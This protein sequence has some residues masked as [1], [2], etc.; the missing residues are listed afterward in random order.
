MARPMTA[1]QT[2]AAL[3]KWG[4]RFR[5]YPGWRSRGRPGGFG[6][7]RGVMVHHTGSNSQSNDY[8]N[9]LF[10]RGRPEDGIPGPL[11]HV[12]TDL[13][14]DLHLGATG[15]ANHAGRGSS[16][17]L[18]RVTAQNH[19]GYTAELRPGDDTVDGNAHYYGNEIRYDGRRAM[20][21]AAYRTALRHAA[22]ICDFHG[23]SALSVIAHR[24]HTRRKADPG[25]CPMNRFRT[26]LAAVLR[27]GPDGDDMANADEVLA[28]LRKFQT[29]EAQRYA[30]LANRVQ[31]LIDQEEGRYADLQRRVQ[32][33]VNQEAGRYQDY[34]RRFNAIL[35]ALPDAANIPPLEPDPSS[36]AEPADP[37][38]D[39]T[40]PEHTDAGTSR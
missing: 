38:H 3:R 33:L 12:A 40:D 26:D 10:V 32:G 11:C 39:H 37:D 29:A 17:T 2:V 23:W 5:E 7:V 34:V 36:P 4:V 18:N 13:D 15:R 16:T 6:D 30:D 19:A 31:G 8:L 9:F 28:E 22:A 35:A 27:A 21:A 14:G 25:F 20:S 1:D 24:E